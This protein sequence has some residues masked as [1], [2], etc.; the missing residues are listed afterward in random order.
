MNQ[1]W[2]PILIYYKPPKKIYWPTITDIVT[3][4]ESKKHH[5]WEQSVDD[6]L[7]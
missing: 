3:G 4:G 1:G 6:A 7:H 2:K 5:D